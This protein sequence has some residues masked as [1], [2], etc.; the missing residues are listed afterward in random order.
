MDKPFALI[1][2]DE[3]D[4]AALFR[5]VL[6]MTGFQTE[7]IHHGQFAMERI[8]HI[9]PD[10]IL[11]DLNLP[12]VSGRQILELIQRDN[13]LSRTK[14]IVIT[15]Y[16]HIANDLSPQPDLVL[17]KPVSVEQLSGLVRRITFGESSPDGMP[18]CQNPVDKQTGLYTQ[19]FFKNRLESSLRQARDSEQYLFAVLLFNL[20]RK[21]REGT[22]SAAQK[23]DSTLLEIADMLRKILRPTDTIAKYD[24]ETFY[25]LIENIP[26]KEFTARIANRIQEILYRNIPDIGNKIRLP[27]RIGIL[28]CDHSYENVDFVLNDAK[29]ALALAEVQGDEYAKY[30]LQVS[31]RSIKRS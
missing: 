14:V 10:I 26:S 7:V 28:V 8:P 1:V 27:V 12:G 6:D 17:Q 20:E 30:Y 16:A 11:L 18:F 15:G 31:A 24:P 22:Q 21:K 2:E 4:I 29:Y 5:N 13:R 3:R 25:I 19:A 23:W 9:K